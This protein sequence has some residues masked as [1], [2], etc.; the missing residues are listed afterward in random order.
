MDA[1]ETLQQ[2]IDDDNE[3]V[4]VLLESIRQDDSAI[5]QLLAELAGNDRITELLSE[6][7]ESN[8]MSMS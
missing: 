3:R 2:M 7:S 4:R 6:L 5:N 1:I 8:L